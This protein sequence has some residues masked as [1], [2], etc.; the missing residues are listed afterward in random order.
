MITTKNHDPTCHDSSSHSHQAGSP[1]CLHWQRW[2][3]EPEP[4]LVS[5]A[6]CCHRQLPILPI[7]RAGPKQYTQ[8]DCYDEIS[9][10][11]YTI[12]A[13]ITN[14]SSHKFKI[15]KFPSCTYHGLEQRF[16]E[17]RERHCIHIYMGKFRKSLLFLFSGPPNP[18]MSQ[19]WSGCLSVMPA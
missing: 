9:A 1:A 19:F 3:Q 10:L 13:L 5:P 16:R 4:T 12:P 6:V 2:L 8:Q 17:K 18:S 14:P 7:P 11:Y 15:R